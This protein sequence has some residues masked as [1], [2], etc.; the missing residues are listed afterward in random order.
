MEKLDF[1]SNDNAAKRKVEED[2]LKGTTLRVYRFLYRHGKPARLTDVQEGLGMSSPSLAMYHLRKLQTAGLIQEKEEGY[3][4]DRI[5]FEN[6]IRIRNAIIPFRI[7]YSAFFA[8]TLVL[9]LTLLRPF[10][11]TPLYFFAIIVNAAAMG[12]FLYETIS[13]VSRNRT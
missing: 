11:L 4:V 5:V 1:L 6:M 7:A 13:V 9:M 12:I 2:V 10:S 8:T 3:V